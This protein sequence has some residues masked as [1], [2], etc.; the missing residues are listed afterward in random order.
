MKKG[1]TDLVLASALWGTI[2]IAVQLAGNPFQVVL[3][4]NLTATA[5]TFNHLKRALNPL[6]VLMGLIAS[7]E[8]EAY[9]FTIDVMGASLASVFLYTA[10]IWVALLSPLLRE[11]VNLRKWAAVMI[12]F[13]G[14]YLIY[15]SRVPL[16]SLGLGLIT[17]LSFAGVILF[18]RFMQL[19]GYRDYEIVAFQ[20]AWGSVFSLPFLV[21]SPRLSVGSMLAGAYLGFAAS[22]IAYYLF[23]RGMRLSDSVTAAVVSSL[24]PVFTMVFAVII[25]H[26]VLTPMQYLGSSLVVVGSALVT[27]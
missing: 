9:F 15:Y 5:L 2:G 22:Y 12:S 20:S 27:A 19:K 24:E 17:G 23:Y 10:P 25:L 14:V 3:F 16:S 6:P 1:A 11:E 7:L 21:L 8:Y 4:R 13:L 26:Q 18:S